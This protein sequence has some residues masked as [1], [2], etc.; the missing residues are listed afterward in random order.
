MLPNKICSVPERLTSLTLILFLEALPGTMKRKRSELL[1]D[2][3]HDPPRYSFENGLR[4]V[5]PYYFE[6]STFAK[7]RWYGKPLLD[8]F[9]QDFKDKPAEYYNSAI[10]NGLITIND[11]SAH[12][13]QKVCPNDVISHLIHRHEAPVVETLIKVVH[14]DE[15]MIVID[16]P[17]SIPVSQSLSSY[18]SQV[19]PSGRYNHNSL[20]GILKAERG[21][22]HLSVIN[23]LDRL[24]SGIVIMGKSR[25]GAAKLHGLMESGGLKKE[26]ICRVRG[27]FPDT[28]KECN[29]PIKTASFK[30][31]LNVVAEDGKECR[32]LFKKI[33][34]DGRFSFIKASPVT[35]RTHQ[36]R[37]HLRHLGY[38]ICNDPLYNDD[39]IWGAASASLGQEQLAKVIEHF[40]NADDEYTGYSVSSS[41]TCIDCANPR[42]DPDCTKMF[43]CLHAFRYSGPEFSFRTD[44]PEWALCIDSKL[45]D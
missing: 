26:Y 2:K 5:K 20:V 18:S 28:I 23:R 8:V 31:A 17:A 16:K 38:P 33:A 29:S 11:S 15:D 40:A 25:E 6:Y 30:L 1:S 32:T 9:K 14:E 36:I 19:H 3:H 35:G 45:L 39:P 24:T 37:V 7:E 10:K 27:D 43:L 22:D 34:F 13:D 44:L 12:P 21:L 42:P 4:Y 41:E